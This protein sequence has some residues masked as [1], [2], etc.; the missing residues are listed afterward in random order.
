MLILV[1]FIGVSMT[2]MAAARR[3]LD[4]VDVRGLHCL[5]DDAAAR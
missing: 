5:V 4:I 2:E 3:V 1:V